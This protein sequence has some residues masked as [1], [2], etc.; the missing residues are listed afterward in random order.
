MSYKTILVHVDDTQHASQRIRYAQNIA[1]QFDAHLTGVALTGISRYIF[2]SSNL[3]AGDP[4]ISF[5]LTLLRERAEQALNQF[6][7]LTADRSASTTEALIANDEANGGLGLRARYCDLIVIGQT[8]LSE[9]SPSVMSDFPEFMIVHS[10]RPILIIPPNFASPDLPKHCLVAWNGSRAATRAITDA[11]PLL[12][13]CEQVHVAIINPKPY[14]ETHGDEPGA[15][16]ALFLARH[17]IKVEVSTR[18]S[19]HPVGDAI[20]ELGKE[21][22]CDLLVMGGYGHSRFREMLMGGATRTILEKSTIPV[23]MSH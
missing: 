23:L 13:L 10:G 15:D 22:Q 6:R 19:K 12:K 7:T 3:G 2:E 11:I 20:L 18:F 9:P 8:N 1:S 16:I 5:H 17:G 14:Q 4:N 21:L